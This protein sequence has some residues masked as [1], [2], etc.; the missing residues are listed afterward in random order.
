MSPD[1]LR[2][3]LVEDEVS[4]R[5]PLTDY[6]TDEIGFA[7]D[8]A[9]GYHEALRL[10]DD[11]RGQ[12]DVALID[13]L[14]I[15]PPDGLRLMRDI[16]AGYPEIECI[17]ATGWGTEERQ[18]ALR[19]GAYHYIEKPF[20]KD[21]LVSLIRAA[22]QQV[23][24]RVIN[25]EVLA[26]HDLGEVLGH[27]SAAALS[28]AQV[29]Q[30]EIR[31]L[32]AVSNKPALYGRPVDLAPVDQPGREAVDDL[33]RR[34]IAT[35][36]T[37]SIANL[38]DAAEEFR[39]LSEMGFQSLVC[40]PIPGERGSLGSLCAYSQAAGSFAQGSD[41]V[42]LQILAGQA[43]LAIANAR[44]FE[45]T[46][47]HAGY[48]EALV[49]ASGQLTRTT[50]RDEQLQLAWDFVREQLRTP[51]FVVAMV[52]RQTG[53]ISFP[54]FYDKGILE[55]QG[56]LAIDWAAT[57]TIIGHVI[58]TG[59]EFF[60]R[61]GDER[62]QVCAELGIS[63]L[64]RGDPCQT[65]LHVPLA[66]G[67][68]VIGAISV[69]AYEPH[70]FSPAFRDAVRALANHLAIAISNS[71]LVTNTRRLADDRQT[72]LGLSLDLASSLDLLRVAERVCR[73]A[74]EFFQAEHSGLLLFEEPYE[75]GEVVAE[76][77]ADLQ[78]VGLQIPLRGVTAEERLLN[79]REPLVI[80]HVAQ[81]DDL[82]PVKD[83][84]LNQL[85]IQ[86][87]LI[88]PVGVE[89]KL[90]GSFSIDA[91]GHE[92]HFSRQQV[93]L[94]KAFAAQ[95]AVAIDRAR[96]FAEAELRA[97]L[98][99]TLDVN[100]HH[101]RAEKDP[102]RLM[103]EFVRLAAEMVGCRS[104]C[105]LRYERFRGELEVAALHNMPA[106]LLHR[107]VGDDEGIIG[108]AARSGESCPCPGYSS[109][110]FS[111][112]LCAGL[113]FEYGIAVP[114][115][116]GSG[117][118]TDVLFLGDDRPAYKLSPD[119]HEVLD[120]FAGQGAI[121][122]QTSQSLTAEKRTYIQREVF[123]KVSE[124]VQAAQDPEK[125]FHVI[126]TG[127]TAGYG[128]GFN[129]A[130]L[131]LT[132]GDRLIGR[133]GIGHHEEAAARIDW[134]GD[135]RQ[136]GA[137]GFDRY[138]ALLENGALKPTPIGQAIGQLNLPAADA[139]VF[140]TV[141]ADQHYRLVYEL[142]QQ[143]LPPAFMA[144][145][146]PAFP[147]LVVALTANKK[148]IGI[149][150]VDN[151][152]TNEPITTELR[153]SL[154][155]YVNHVAIAIENR[156]LYNDSQARLTQVEQ[157][158]Q[159][160]GVVAEAVAQHTRQQ[161][162]NEIADYTRTVLKA[163]S[164]VLYACDEAGEGL[165]DWG[166]SHPEQRDPRS[167]VEPGKLDK[168]SSTPYKLLRLDEEY[169]R[170]EDGDFDGSVLGGAYIRLEGMTASFGVPLRA[171]EEKMGVMFVN[172]RAAHR[173]S[174]DDID[175]IKM[176][177]HLAAAAIRIRQLAD[178]AE[179]RAND[180]KLLAQI[181]QEASSLELEPFLESLFGRLK[182]QFGERDNPV[183][184]NLGVYDDAKRSLELIPTR[185]YPVEIRE[186]VQ[187]IDRQKS[188]MTWVAKTGREYYADDV[189]QDDHYNPI[190]L[191]TR[192][193]YAAPIF[194]G[195]E[196]LGVLDLESPQPDRFSLDDHQLI[197]NI[198]NQ[199]ASALHNVKQYREL[200]EARVKVG[201][202][203]ALA[204]M[205]IISS[206][207]RHQIGNDV[208][209]ILN[210]LNLLR[211]DL[212]PALNDTVAHHLRVMERVARRIQ[213]IPLAPPSAEDVEPFPLCELVA[214][215][216]DDLATTRE[217]YRAID[218]S[219][220]CETIENDRVRASPE[221]IKRL[222]DILAD[223]A[224]EAMSD[225][226]TKRLTARVRRESG[227]LIVTIADTGRGI[228]DEVLKLLFQDPLKKQKD[229]K[230]SGMGLLMA[231]LIVETYGGGIKV[232][233][234]GNQGTTMRFWLP[235][236]E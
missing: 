170:V 211:G 145:F 205:G 81:Q 80:N 183:S 207:Y 210:T 44:A 192:S 131:L 26:K 197:K 220:Q 52:E 42:P 30:V 217:T 196:L 78:A 124:Y 110:P 68:E 224:A 164:V 6:L 73:A 159:A 11:N 76:Y 118:V 180:F 212:G 225:A 66:A 206:T 119:A 144:A 97:R 16:K 108:Q 29:D 115:R 182:K 195:G 84:L 226:V 10:I 174:D 117:E 116:V 125:I 103:H 204:W 221:L 61:T 54:L 138:I 175:T 114:L 236:E 179:R 223:N 128:L 34:I 99:E 86:S 50:D 40:V 100:T 89:D 83:I 134:R 140:S 166:Y 112:P 111:D 75:F 47:T 3:L 218:C 92:R 149:L 104:G 162:L 214:K 142:E 46:R 141:L 171:V 186:N 48:M 181:G 71:R 51:T 194:F 106:A 59:R 203:T 96:L 143:Q 173:F 109:S 98:L 198:V 39:W 219:T 147:L 82:G 121:A 62:D 1:R 135:E 188:I 31:L 23:R 213:K 161:T 5:R 172:Y 56:P 60:S 88:V 24:L 21:E 53:T 129:R 58:A 79:L 14:L 189:D 28:L 94:A 202:R 36:K 185:Y 222:I 133:Q 230:G 137:V 13:R 35:G 93:D 64:S 45:E 200:N 178:A 122:L 27:I 151:K 150:V 102:E 85:N 153:Q 152:F 90:L 65:C 215:R 17:I 232:E 105:L 107:R 229:E 201:T 87:T 130:A 191:G 156:R 158:R 146:Q 126:L 15:P 101:I 20:D 37:E 208:P 184:L 154:V 32:D 157:T 25:R 132:D 7:V 120:R 63:S 72:L 169:Q 123:L 91:V 69:Q 227:H 209:T 57:N 95:A 160:A 22:G 148:S 19:E 43:S 165:I 2:L 199:I 139:G 127:V 77:P 8:A 4:L 18:T 41:I 9:A 136:G 55:E 49:R 235:I 176:F 12:Y 187:S 163:D 233:H 231:Q 74:V 113:G 168:V 155:T 177:A 167:L 228:P 190:L 70:A 193:E 67:G 38:A 216:I 33:T 234:T